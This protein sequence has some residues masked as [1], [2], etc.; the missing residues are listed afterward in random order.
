MK[1]VMRSVAYAV[2][3]L[4][5]A[6]TVFVIRSGMATEIME[7]GEKSIQNALLISLIFVP[8]W[9]AVAGLLLL[10]RKSKK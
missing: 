4:V 9:A 7:W 5:I 2:L 6:A 1:K 8:P 3:T 10:V